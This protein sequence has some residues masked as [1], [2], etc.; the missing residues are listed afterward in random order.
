[1]TKT[2]NLD[3]IYKVTRICQNALAKKYYVIEIVTIEK[4]VQKVSMFK[5]ILRYNVDC[6]IT[7]NNLRLLNL[8]VKAFS[9]FIK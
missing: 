4:T 7:I 1:M 9:Y 8:T 3:F 2:K 5:T 6:Y